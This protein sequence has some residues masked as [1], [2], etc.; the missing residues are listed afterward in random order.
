VENNLIGSRVK[1]EYS[2]NGYPVIYTDK[3]VLIYDI[4]NGEIIYTKEEDLKKTTDSLK[5]LE[6]SS[7]KWDPSFPKINFCLT[8]KCNLACD[9]CAVNANLKEADVSE[10]MIDSIFRKYIG[11]DAQKIKI[12]FTGGEPTIC[13]DK[14]KYIVDKIRKLNLNPIYIINTN[15]MA[16]KADL[17]YLVQNKFKFFISIDGLKEIHDNHRKNVSGKGSFDEVINN[18]K[19]LIDQEACVVPRATVTKES[20]NEMPNLVEF[21]G[22]LGIKIFRIANVMECGRAKRISVTAPDAEEY[23]N[24]LKKCRKIAKKYK[25]SLISSQYINLFSP[26]IHACATMTGQEI[27]V[28]P[29]GNIT[30]CFAVYR[31]EDFMGDYFIIGKYDSAK[32]EIIIDEEKKKRL[33]EYN[34]QNFEKCEKCFCKYI[35]SAACPLLHA[36]NA[37]TNEYEKISDKYC[38]FAKNELRAL[39]CE[40]K[41]EILA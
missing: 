16:N 25:M 20:L 40:G 30:T 1:K 12:N 24:M 5:T 23:T 18:L 9:Y 34:V 29:N 22:G 33:Q 41:D 32:D 35:C 14:I 26:S 3:Q 8:F 37:D 11:R 36:L 27:I 10:K 2:Y 17:D 39:F 7:K 6:I 38:N 21:L 28:A 15:G 13:M 19:Y 4:L 31:K